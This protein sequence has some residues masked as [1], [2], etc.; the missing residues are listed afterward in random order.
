MS[1][2]IPA[3]VILHVDDD[4]DVL[5]VVGR[6]LG[7]LGYSV[8]SV[9]DPAEAIEKLLTTDIRVVLL[10]V[11]MPGRSGIELLRE[12]KR[13]DGGVQVVML[14]GVTTM[15]CLMDAFRGGAEACFFKPLDC[16][17]PLAEAINGSFEKIEHWRAALVRLIQMRRANHAQCKKLSAVLANRVT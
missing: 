11:D 4:P 14:T 9:T 10:D 15:Q 7:K 1:A 12:I 3:R 5:R 13:L 2:A 8:V 6:Q 17:E 16:C